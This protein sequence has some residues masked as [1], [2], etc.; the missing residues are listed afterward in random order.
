MSPPGG[1][2]EVRVIV[3][4]DVLPPPVTAGLIVKLAIV[5]GAAVLCEPGWRPKAISDR[6]SEAKIISRRSGF[7]MGFPESSLVVII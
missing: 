7:G 4:V 3:P 5:G 2:A 1:A 6:Q